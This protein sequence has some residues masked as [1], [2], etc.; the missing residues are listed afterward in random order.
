MR[1][2]RLAAIGLL[3][4]ALVSACAAGVTDQ[5]AAR[6]G[7]YLGS[8]SGTLD[9]NDLA[10]RGTVEFTIAAGSAEGVFVTGLGRRVRFSGT[11]GGRLGAALGV[12]PDPD[13]GCS[14]VAGSYSDIAFPGAP[15]RAG[16]T[17]SLGCAEFTAQWKAERAG[18]VLV[19]GRRASF[20]FSVPDELP[21]AR[22]GA[23]YH[24]SFCDPEP[25]S[26]LVCGGVVAQPLKNP[27]GGSQPYGFQK[28][29]GGSLPWGLGLSNSGVL[30]GIPDDV[31]LRRPD[32]GAAGAR[33]EFAVCAVD[34]TR[35][36]VC[37]KTAIR[38]Q[39]APAAAS[40]SPQPTATPFASPTPQ[41]AVATAPPVS[42]APPAVVVVTAP[43]V[44]A[45]PPPTPTP[46]PAPALPVIDGTWQGTWRITNQTACFAVGLSQSWRATLTA[47]G[48]RLS[49][50]FSGGEL[51][52]G[53]VS[54]SVAGSR[55]TWS[56]ANPAGGIGADLVVEVT[57][58]GAT[59]SG[60][61]RDKCR[62]LSSSGAV[63]SEQAITGT[64]TA[65]RP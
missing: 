1:R 6:E 41:P 61:I 4:A 50:T 51:G 8:F 32:A 45:V 65:G 55:L 46:A 30:E 25:A 62:V 22:A 52:S 39:G 15:P 5:E 26:G 13:T 31:N 3:S 24:Y 44:V 14:Q 37:A 19:S 33:F 54:G 36:F 47:T 58:S 43:P 21:T 28:E 42:T 20:T 9:P 7:T 2:L 34:S 53:G 48:A 35:S 64:I 40:P 23:P 63:I 10:R 29:F 27:S 57:V 16:F 49:G 11:F 17:G 56:L 59:L 12:T 18:P 60:T 38:V